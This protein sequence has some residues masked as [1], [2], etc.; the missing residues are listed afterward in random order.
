MAR[1]HR[2]HKSAGYRGRAAVPEGAG[3]QAAL[4]GLH[5]G[6]CEVRGDDIGGIAVHIGARVSALAGPNKVLAKPCSPVR[7]LTAVSGGVKECRRGVRSRHCAGM[8]AVASGVAAQHC[9]RS[10]W[11]ARP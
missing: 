6:E 1:S 5:T 4:A 11:L 8:R 10:I 2:P 9:L 3:T 7:D